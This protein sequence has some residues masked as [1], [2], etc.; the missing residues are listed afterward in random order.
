MLD[1][2]GRRIPPRQPNTEVVAQAVQD[3]VPAFRDEGQGASREIGM[4]RD[5]QAPDE[6]LVDVDLGGRRG[7]QTCP[8]QASAMSGET[9]A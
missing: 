8:R 6:P 7:G 4:L 3:V 2:R 9:T 5:E 1:E